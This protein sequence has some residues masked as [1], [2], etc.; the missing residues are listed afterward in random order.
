MSALHK[1]LAQAGRQVSDFTPNSKMGKIFRRRGVSPS[2]ELDRILAL[3][4][5]EWSEKDPKFIEMMDC[6]NDPRVGFRR[7]NAPMKL[8]PIQAM[9]LADIHDYGGLFGPVAVGFGKTI[10]SLLAPVVVGAK[11]PLLILPAKLIE[12]TRREFVNYDKS[13]NLMPIAMLSYEMLGREKGELLLLQH[14]PDMIIADEAHRL[15]NTSAAVTRRVARFVKHS[16]TRFVALSGTITKRSLRDYWHIIRWCLPNNCP[17]PT[18]LVEFEEWALALDERIMDQRRM[19]YGALESL[20]TPEES[21]RLKRQTK[22]DALQTIRGAYRRRLVETPGVVATSEA[23]LG[24]SLRILGVVP[25]M[26]KNLDSCFELLRHPDQPETP[27][28]HPIM[29]HFEQWRHARELACGFFYRWNP[30]PP[31]EWLA[32]RKAWAKFVREILSKPFLGYDSELPVAKACSR[33]ELPRTQY[34][35][36]R[37]IKSTFEPKTETVW[38][39]DGMLN[40]A[41]Q[42]LLDHRQGGIVWVEHL[43]FGRE[44]A[45]RTG[46][47]FYAAKGM[48][49]GSKQIIEEARGPIIASIGSNSEGRNLQHYSESLVVS[50]PPNGTVWEQL[51]GRTHRPGQEADEVIYDVAFACKEQIDGFRT[52][53]KDAEYQENSIG[54]QQKLLYADIVLGEVENMKGARWDG[55]DEDDFIIRAVRKRLNTAE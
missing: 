47:A 53:C 32:K 38:I 45:R 26:S 30:R 43:A 22:D 55:A 3:P 9:A 27:D 13:F 33:N 1:M 2:K 15:K 10:I 6:L 7:Y 17:L 51:L 21:Q 39:D 35:E 41:H 46:L 54:S 36:W 18:T 14:N 24:T 28:G 11:R 19:H 50:C 4:R 52:A 48:A 5:R 23:V 25:K 37:A 40:L 12:K 29:D 49:E 44:L 42:W 16:P 20:C 31:A 34:D 8:R